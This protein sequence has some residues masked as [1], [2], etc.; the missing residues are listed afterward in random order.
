MGQDAAKLSFVLI[1][2]QL[3]EVQI[4]RQ[5]AT[6]LNSVW[7]WNSKAALSVEEGDH[8]LWP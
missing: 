2:N 6:K 1:T 5:I 4:C 8:I 3:A 7:A